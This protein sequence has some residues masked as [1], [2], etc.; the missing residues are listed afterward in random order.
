M[1]KYTLVNSLAIKL[2]MVGSLGN[3]FSISLYIS[4]IDDISS[5]SSS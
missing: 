1:N 3:D 2:K 4:K 5:K